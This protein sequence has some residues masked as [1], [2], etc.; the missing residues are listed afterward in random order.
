MILAPVMGGCLILGFGFA[1]V[2]HRV[3]IRRMRVSQLRNALVAEYVDKQLWQ[4]VSLDE[5]LQGNKS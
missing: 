3:A 1:E 4:F 5:W 2:V